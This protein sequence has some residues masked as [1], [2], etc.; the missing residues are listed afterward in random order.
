MAQIR[1]LWETHSLNLWY[2]RTNRRTGNYIYH[3][4]FHNAFLKNLNLD[5][6]SLVSSPFVSLYLVFTFFFFTRFFLQLTIMHVAPPINNRFF[7]YTFDLAWSIKLGIMNVCDGGFALK[8]AVKKGLATLILVSKQQR[9][10]KLSRWR[11]WHLCF[12]HFENKLTILVRVVQF[13][14]GSSE[15]Q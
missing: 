3:L 1:S 4:N 14:W 15:R 12:E 7:F 9:H 8:L 10:W 13:C 6:P 2:R 5:C 11:T